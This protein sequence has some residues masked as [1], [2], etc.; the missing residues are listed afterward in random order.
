MLCKIRRFGFYGKK[1][2]GGASGTAEDGPEKK[3]PT[4]VPLAPVPDFAAWLRALPSLGQLT[5]GEMDALVAQ[6]GGVGMDDFLADFRQ[7][8]R[9]GLMNSL[10]NDFK[11]STAHAYKIA[12]AVQEYHE[13]HPDQKRQ[14]LARESD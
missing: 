9:A 1:L 2:K 6:L 4:P 7:N 14:R 10:Q 11:V 3:M 13:G 5:Q 12:N 8:E